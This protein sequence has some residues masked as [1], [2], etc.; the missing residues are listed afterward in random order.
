MDALQDYGES[1]GG[2]DEACDALA[3]A[4]A[5]LQI[6]PVN[7]FVPLGVQPPPPLPP[8]SEAS[9]G[10]SSSSEGAVPPRALRH[11]A[12]VAQ[13]AMDSAVFE[14]QLREEE[15]RRLQQ[16][17]AGSGTAAASQR[18]G[19][20]RRRPGT[21]EKDA[22]S[23]TYVGPWAEPEEE[24]EEE[25][26]PAVEEKPQ[27]VE[28]GKGVRGKDDKEV[29]GKQE[30]EEDGEDENKE[31]EKEEK[32]KKSKKAK[33]DPEG[34][35]SVVHLE[36]TCDYQGRSFVEPPRG[37]RAGLG[38]E[39]PRC[40]VPG[41]CVATAAHAH[42][43][44]TACVRVV[45]R[46]GHL[47]LSAGL[48]GVA[49]LWTVGA[50]GALACAVSYHGH[51]RAV[52]DACFA[53]D[54]RRFV[55]CAYDRYVKLWDTETGAVVS[56]CT[57]G[58]TPYCAR[59]YAGNESECLCGTSQRRVVQWDFRTRAVVQEYEEHQ[60]SVNAVL[61][62]DGNRRFVSSSDD[63]S[64]RVWDYG[65][66]VPVKYISEPAM[67]SM[68]ALALHPGGRYFACQSM[69]NQ[70]CVY[71][72]AGSY[73]LL[74]RKRFTGH[75]PAGYACQLAFSPDGRYLVSGDASGRLWVWGWKSGRL[76]RTLPAHDGV[77]IGVEWHPL[78]PSRVF[79]CGW[80]GSIKSWD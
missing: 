67:N 74:P 39:A 22:G 29:Q 65:I 69:D 24:E 19:H 28:E 25:E 4:R 32:E 46:Y 5:A 1:S 13:Y 45:P 41:R 43:R 40:Y 55:T 15:R 51:S 66:P 78:Q 48:D 18:R 8:P 77:A 6:A 38:A 53:A 61:F 33:E 70:I 58:K 80:D 49:K 27:D 9:T 73:R 79:S 23:G 63:K 64:L 20:R 72:A 60:A 54:G 71:E 34:G 7:A 52:R 12:S 31:K 17:K 36:E 14:A 57:N 56:A 16:T 47:L 30:K 35:Y 2:E 62:I 42:G 68:P 21:S 10:R 59:L 26:I 75:T 50:D 37:V 3:R 76:L 11:K 44:G